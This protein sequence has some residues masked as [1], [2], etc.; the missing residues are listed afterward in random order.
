MYM[1]MVVA[2]NFEHPI[3]LMTVSGAKK[4]NVRFLEG[5]QKTQ[6]IFIHCAVEIGQRT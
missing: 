6:N 2:L 5:M 3:R 4:L 1:M